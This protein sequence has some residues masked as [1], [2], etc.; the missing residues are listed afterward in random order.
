MPWVKLDDQ[1]FGNVKARAAGKDGRELY[2]AGLCF[3]A[4]QLTDGRIPH[5]TLPVLAA[6][7]QVKAKPTV[8]TLLEVGLWRD[9]G[10]HYVIN[11][12]GEYNE[13]AEKVRERRER[14][15]L[16]KQAQRRG[17]DGKYEVSPGDTNGDGRRDSPGDSPPSRPVPSFTDEPHPPPTHV[18][19]SLSDDELFAL[20]VDKQLAAAKAAGGRI[21]SERAWRQEAMRRARVELG[22]RVAE[23][24]ATFVLEDAQLADAAIGNTNILKTARRRSA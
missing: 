9:A 20:I 14:D 21:T 3:A 10:D 12:Y 11:G 18:N 15:R 6:L 23:L 7:A 4:S 8:K 19:G 1:F 16:K 2:L 5:D 22:P 17:S 13:S 24:R